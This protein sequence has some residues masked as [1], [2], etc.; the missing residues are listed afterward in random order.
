MRKQLGALA[1][2]VILSTPLLL[3]VA[4]APKSPS[5][6]LTG[7]YRFNDGHLMT[8]SYS[9]ENTFR[10]RDVQSGKSQRLYSSGGP[11]FHSGPGWASPSPVE[12]RVEARQDGAGRVTGLDWQPVE[13]EAQAA[14]RLPLRER[15]VTF[16]SGD[17]ELFGKLVL[18]EGEGP[19]P[20]VV[21]AHGSEATAASQF[22]HEPY[23][24]APHGIATFV[25]DK[26][27]TG[28]SQGKYGMDF[29]VLAGDVL[30]AVEWLRKQPGIDPERIGLTGYSQG[31]WI[32]PMAASRSNGAV[33]FV[34]VGYGLAEP[35]SE[36]D[37]WET[38]AELRDKGYGEEEIRK[39]DEVISATQEILRS[40]LR[41]GWRTLSQLE[42]KYGKEPWLRQMSGTPRVFL[43]YPHWMLR[44][45]ARPWIPPL[46][47]WF[48]DPMPVLST[49]DVPMLWLIGGQDVEAIPEVTIRRLTELQAQGR[50]VE[51]KIFPTADH[52][53]LEFEM[54]DGQRV[55]TGYS[56]GYFQTAIDWL[57]GQAG[58]K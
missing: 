57:R 3:S 26:R 13:G 23:L 56:P 34:L 12:L 19:H 44:A 22:Y 17:L 32:A 49:L 30:A 47:A 4:C 37:R 1:R 38:L 48:Y 21:V 14:E 10:Y 6:N 55:Y 58:L 41:N 20:A 31:G 9:A 15:T 54:K 29:P 46:R 25:F 35:P 51:L 27:G 11:S 8:I 42:R 7:A 33:K 28:R 45:F 2:L 24:L 5:L 40:D 36:E 53:I 16:R 50:P 43:R 18:P 52:G 39:A